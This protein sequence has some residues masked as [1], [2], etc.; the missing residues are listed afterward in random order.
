[1]NAVD[2]SLTQLTKIKFNNYHCASEFMYSV[3]NISTINKITRWN[4]EKRKKR[5]RER[6][7]ERV[8]IVETFR[9]VSRWLKWFLYYNITW[10][11][12]NSNFCANY[13]AIKNLHNRRTVIT[14]STTNIFTLQ[15]FRDEISSFAIKCALCRP[16]RSF[17]RHS[18]IFFSRL[19]VRQ[20]H[21][22]I[23]ALEY[24]LCIF[25]RCIRGLEIF[26][27]INKNIYRSTA[28]L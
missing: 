24:S 1:M 27:C 15:A 8:H 10:R 28:L 25:V 18:L 5:E 4:R 9:C 13:S 12:W 6:E 20:T 11:W 7:R 3:I 2:V 22:Y 19:N 21:Y 23:L 26:T 17:T 16:L 14:L